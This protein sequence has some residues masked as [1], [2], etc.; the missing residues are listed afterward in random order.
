V[1]DLD[2]AR[3]SAQLCRAHAD[4]PLAEGR[5]V[6]RHELHRVTRSEL[7]VAGDD[8]NGEQAPSIL[9]E[10]AMSAPVHDEAAGAGLR[11][12]QP[13]LEGARTASLLRDE[14]RAAVLARDD[15]REHVPAASGRDR[16]RHTRGRGEPRCRDLA[17][18][19]AAAQLARRADHHVVRRF[20]VGQQLRSRGRGM[21]GVDAVH[22]CQQDEEA[23]ARQHGDLG[24]ERIVVAEGDL[25]RGRGVVLV[26]DRHDAQLQQSLECVARVDVARPLGEVRRREED[27]AGFEALRTQRGSPRRLQPRLTDRRRRLQP[28]RRVWTSRQ[29]ESRQPE[30][31]RSGRHDADAL[32][33]ADERS[34]LGGVRGELRTPHAP[35]PVDDERGAELD[36]D[37]H[38]CWLPSPTT[39]YCLNQRSR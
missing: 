20:A 31:D 19:S 7:A 38:R 5:A 35:A 39:R 3:P 11:V 25:V 10:R 16:R 18:H 29:A 12:T 21:L 15:G 33:G 2:A 14:A 6:R 37:R 22:L 24:R 28:R 8:P 32:A 13:E 27:L 26:H 23:R 9:D 30:C 36:D 17:R 34:D 1:D 4:E